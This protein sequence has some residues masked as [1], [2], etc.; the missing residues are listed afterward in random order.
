MD[1]GIGVSVIRS[2][3]RREVRGRQKHRELAMPERRERTE[4]SADDA[5]AGVLARAERILWRTTLRLTRAHW[6]QLEDIA[7][8]VRRAGARYRPGSS[9]IARGVLDAVLP[10][11]RK[12]DFVSLADELADLEREDSRAIVSEWVRRAV[13]KRLQS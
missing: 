7:D 1:A 3:A 9:E 8:S 10:M 4:R 2:N 11:L 12:Q 13:A 6:H 5:L